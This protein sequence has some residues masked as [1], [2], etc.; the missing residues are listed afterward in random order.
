M[1]E[2]TFAFDPTLFW[3]ANPKKYSAYPT[4]PL[5]KPFKSGERAEARS[6]TGELSDSKHLSSSPSLA[7]SGISS[8][9]LD[10]PDVPDSQNTQEHE[11]AK[12]S[13]HIRSGHRSDQHRSET[14]RRERHRSERHRSDTARSEPQRAE[15]SDSGRS[16]RPHPHREHHHHKNEHEARHERHD[17]QTDDVVRLTS[18][19]KNP[20]MQTDSLELSPSP[21]DFFSLC[22]TKKHSGEK[23]SPEKVDDKEGRK[24]QNYPPPS[25][26]FNAPLSHLSDEE[27]ELIRQARWFH[28]KG[29]DIPLYDMSADME[30]VYFDV[31]RI[32]ED[33][34]MTSHIKNMKKQYIMYATLI[35]AVI[36]MLPLGIQSGDIK[37]NVVKMLEREEHNMEKDY[38]L[39]GAIKTD[40][41]SRDVQLAFLMVLLEGIL[42]KQKQPEPPLFPQP[43]YMPMPNGGMPNGGMPNGGIPNGGVDTGSAPG[44]AGGEPKRFER[45]SRAAQPAAGGG[46]LLGKVLP[47]FQSFL[48]VDT[49]APAQAPPPVR[50]LAPSMP[51]IYTPPVYINPPTI[52][53]N[54]DLEKVT[55]QLLAEMDPEEETDSVPEVTVNKSEDAA[56]PVSDVPEV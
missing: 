25:K 33:L 8:S 28:N 17:R 13:R 55:S 10:T 27:R 7:P 41:P 39:N 30:Q 42:T 24:A 35:Q 50:P 46:G 5:P 47:L 49:Q 29:F 14:G 54:F 16:Q 22:H 31:T 36:G 15:R 34:E 37:Q 38:Y 1:D 12:R 11:R 48:G 18:N 3:V 6:E 20:D 40:N 43:Y 45:K 9:Q 56:V 44:P 19:P 26:K 53:A 32:N 21:F 23:E 51:P 4:K 2:K 52:D